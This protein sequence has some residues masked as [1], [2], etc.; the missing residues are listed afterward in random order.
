[1]SLVFGTMEYDMGSKLLSKKLNRSF[2]DLP[3]MPKLSF[4]LLDSDTDGLE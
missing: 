3:E 1:M 2:A 4:S